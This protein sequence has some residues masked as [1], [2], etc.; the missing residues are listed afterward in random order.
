MND[1]Q[2]ITY[3]EIVAEI[4]DIQAKLKDHQE[5]RHIEGSYRDLLKRL[6]YLRNRQLTMKK[7]R[8]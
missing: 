1:K 3:E 6:Q 8:G 7:K 4:K 2:K 5:G